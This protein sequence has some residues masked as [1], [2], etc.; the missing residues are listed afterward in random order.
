MRFTGNYHGPMPK[1]IASIQ[2]RDASIQRFMNGGN[3][4]GFV[5]MAIHPRLL[6]TSKGQRKNFKPGGSKVT[7]HHKGSLIRKADEGTARGDTHI[8]D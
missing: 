3:T 6:H 8:D 5:C 4:F 7:H 2:K 1:K